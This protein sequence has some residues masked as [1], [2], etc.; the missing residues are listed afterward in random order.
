MTWKN[1]KKMNNLNDIAVA[2]REHAENLT[3]DINKT[4]SRVEYIRITQLAMEAARLA[5]AIEHLAAT[6]NV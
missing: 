2:A 5:E 4:S 6:S 1:Q 3:E